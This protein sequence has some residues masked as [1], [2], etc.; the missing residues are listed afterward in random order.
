MDIKVPSTGWNIHKKELSGDQEHKVNLYRKCGFAGTLISYLTLSSSDKI[1][2]ELAIRYVF[3][4]AKNFSY[5]EVNTEAVINFLMYPE[6]PDAVKIDL[7]VAAPFSERQWYVKYAEFKDTELSMHHLCNLIPDQMATAVVKNMDLFLASV[8]L[9]YMPSM[10]KNLDLRVLPSGYKPNDDLKFIKALYELDPKRSSTS[11]WNIPRKYY[12][13][14]KSI[15]P[16]DKDERLKIITE[17]IEHALRYN[18]SAIKEFRRQTI[19]PFYKEEY[20]LAAVTESGSTISYIEPKNR[21]Q[22]I[23]DA[24]VRSTPSA[25]KYVP[26]SKHNKHI[27]LEQAIKADTIMKYAK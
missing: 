19:A 26:K 4:K 20:G 3:Q 12:V 6:I 21:T 15:R 22:A 16:S 10:Y 5:H 24:A 14:D 9:K 23:C 8:L 2:Y 1:K 25:L 11:I 17:V 13:Q 7:I 27:I 18:P